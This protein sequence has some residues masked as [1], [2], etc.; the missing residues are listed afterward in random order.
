MEACPGTVHC[1]GERARVKLRASFANS[2]RRGEVSGA[3]FR[4]FI[5]SGDVYEEAKGY[6]ARLKGFSKLLD[7]LAATADR[8]AEDLGKWWTDQFLYEIQ[9]YGLSV[10]EFLDAIER[11]KTTGGIRR[12]VS[13]DLPRRTVHKDRATGAV[14]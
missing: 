9:P 7:E 14:R 1:A 13:F 10:D 5:E 11:G 6:M 4:T 2:V 8:D 12:L 3:G